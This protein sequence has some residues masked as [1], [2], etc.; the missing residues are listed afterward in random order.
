MEELEQV[1]E[2]VINKGDLSLSELRHMRDKVLSS[3]DAADEAAAR[4][5]NE[6]C[7]R[8]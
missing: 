4:K 2:L 1:I 3:P 5:I 8:G 6:I 7:S